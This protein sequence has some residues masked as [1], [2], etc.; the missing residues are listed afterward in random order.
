MTAH[1]AGFFLLLIFLVPALIGGTPTAQTRTTHTFLAERFYN[2]FSGA[3]P[4]A[5]RIKPGDRVV[6]KT[7]DGTGGG[8]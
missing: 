6:T 3:P 2:T 1:R 7:P 5:L 4:A 8:I